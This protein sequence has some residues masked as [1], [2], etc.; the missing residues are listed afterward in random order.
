MLLVLLGIF[1]F[2]LKEGK[3][4]KRPRSLDNKVQGEE[5]IVSELAWDSLFGTEKKPF[6]TQ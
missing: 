5:S 2:F 4:F 1:F 3:S 6:K